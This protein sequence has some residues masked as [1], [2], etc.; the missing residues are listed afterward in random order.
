[1]SIL[2]VGGGDSAL[3]RR[4]QLALVDEF[5]HTNAPGSRHPKRY[6]DVLELLD[7][8]IEII[9]YEASFLHAKVA[10]MDAAGGALATV[11]S[12]NLDP[13]SLLL[14]REANV[15]VRNDTFAAEL[16]GQLMQ[17]IAQQG[18]RVEPVRVTRTIADGD[19][20]SVLPRQIGVPRLGRTLAG[21]APNSDSQSMASLPLTWA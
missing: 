1:M 19:R 18:R 16:R 4:P 20:I 7:A 13:L 5:A 12:S 15:F 14:A 6:Q 2:V 21:R 17:A 8:G 11:G 10:V 9:E 3:A